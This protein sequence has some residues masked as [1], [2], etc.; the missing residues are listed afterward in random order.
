MQTTTIQG[1]TLTG[2][3]NVS[4]LFETL[5][6][7]ARESLKY[8]NLPYTPEK[9]ENDNIHSDPERI[10][11]RINVLIQRYRYHKKQQLLA[12]EAVKRREE[13]HCKRIQSEAITVMTRAN[14]YRK[15][16][17]SGLGLTP[18]RI[19]LEIFYRQNLSGWVNNELREGSPI[20]LHLL[21]IAGWGEK[22]DYT[23]LEE[24]NT[25]LAGLRS[26]AE[27]LIE[28]T[29]IIR[30]QQPERDKY[31]WKGE[32]IENEPLPGW[33]PP[34][35]EEYSEALDELCII[36]DQIKE[37]QKEVD[38]ELHRTSNLKKIPENFCYH[39][40]ELGDTLEAPGEL[41]IKRVWSM[42]RYYLEKLA[43][44]ICG[45]YNELNV[46]EIEETRRQ[47]KAKTDAEMYIQR[48]RYTTEET[49]ELIQ[50]GKADGMRQTEIAE[51]LKIGLRTVQRYW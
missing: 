47:Q 13:G 48:K 51:E 24:L 20:W 26:K 21:Y 49:K 50:I 3:L 30:K 31:N 46:M 22:I 27:P 19:R 17:I 11:D 4:K 7:E 45:F 28:K 33:M 35:R 9:G 29:N 40:F 44:M 25:K 10:A 16:Q 12:G 14:F 15:S 5:E 41:V 37:L 38:E 43:A 32:E 34:T 18:E 39:L 23:H 6:N 36:N 2:K 1:Q 8:G 42:S